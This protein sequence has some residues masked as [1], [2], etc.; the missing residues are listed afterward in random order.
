MIFFLPLFSLLSLTLPCDSLSAVCAGCWE[1]AP[2]DYRVLA[3]AVKEL[4]ER[5][6]RILCKLTAIHV[7]NFM[8]QIVAGVNYRFDLVV[9]HSTS[10]GSHCETPA[11][12]ES[13][14]V[15]VLDVPWENFMSLTEGDCHTLIN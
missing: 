15:Q 2:V 9:K 14:H 11:S 4:E 5:E 8:T 6:E 12:T 7:Q 3:F 10:W 13:C 1:P